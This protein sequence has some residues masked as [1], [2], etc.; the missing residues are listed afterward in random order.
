MCSRDLGI[1]VGTGLMSTQCAD[2]CTCL[3]A[4]PLLLQLDC[5]V[6]QRAGC[7]CTW[8]FGHSELEHGPAVV[9]SD[10]QAVCQHGSTRA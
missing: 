2:V 3:R 9:N 5:I 6:K 8:L 4:T 10:R 7:L 1:Q